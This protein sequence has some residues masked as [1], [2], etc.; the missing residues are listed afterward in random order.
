[1]IIEI[2]KR[3]AHLTTFKKYLEKNSPIPLEMPT[4]RVE[5]ESINKLN[6]SESGDNTTTNEN[7]K[8]NIHTWTFGTD[9]FWWTLRKT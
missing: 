6:A 8:I 4:S 9:N 5:S 2:K 1:M 7:E 3:E